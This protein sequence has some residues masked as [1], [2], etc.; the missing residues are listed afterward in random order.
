M[1]EHESDSILNV[2]NF[3]E[4]CGREESW[5]RRPRLIDDGRVVCTQC[6]KKHNISVDGHDWDMEKMAKI[7]KLQD[8][9]GIKPPLRKLIS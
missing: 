2:I 6:I 7:R 8:R 1:S 9:F 4:V 3:C 5:N